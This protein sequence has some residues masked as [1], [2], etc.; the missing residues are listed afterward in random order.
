M[1]KRKRR[2]F[3][4]EFKAQA[5]RI[6]R[7]SGKSVG[8]VARELD[9]TETALRSWVRQAEIDA[10]RGTSGALTTEEREELGRLRREN[11]TLRMERDIL[12]KATAFFAKEKAVFPVRVLCRTLQV[13]RAGFY[14]WQ[15]RPPAPR[16]RADERLGL[17][18]A[19]IHAETRQRYGSPRIHAE[20]GERGCRTGRK[21]VARLMRVRGLAA[22]RRRRFRVT[23]QSR[24]PFPIAPNV[25]A[26]QFERTGP[27]QAWVTEITYIPTGEGWLYL[28]VILDL[29]SRLAVGWAMNERITDDLT[30]DALGMA[31][32]RRRPPQGLLHHSDRGSQYASGDYQRAL[33][34]HGIVCSMSRRG[35]CWDNAVAE[36]FFATLKVELVHDATWAT[37]TAARSELFDYLE[38]FYNGRRRHSTGAARRSAAADAPGPASCPST[39]GDAPQSLV[40]FLYSVLHDAGFIGDDGTV[41]GAL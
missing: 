39:K 18:I 9:L 12:K 10:G 38:V 41:S 32:A 25:L 22:L 7:E 2:A 27:D 23:T 26:R 37:R 30:L 33:A 36:S 11:R 40:L 20:L 35:D 5:V 17:E 4:R 16:A 1:A 24:H 13:S 8:V 34:Q 28:A 6:V 19:A 15:A 21:R 31:L 14:A 3:T 29:C